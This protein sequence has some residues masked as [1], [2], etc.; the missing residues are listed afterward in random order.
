MNTGL[1]LLLASLVTVSAVENC[2]VQALDL[3]PQ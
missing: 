2:R 1:L 3:G